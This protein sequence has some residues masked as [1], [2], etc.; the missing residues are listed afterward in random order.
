MKT[1]NLYSYYILKNKPPGITAELYAYTTS[2]KYAKEFESARNMKIFRKEKTTIDKES[3]EYL[4]REYNYQYLVEYSMPVYDTKRKIRYDL[5]YI[6]TKDECVTINTEAISLMYTDIYNNCWFSP[7]IFKKKIHD[8]LE[9]LNYNK[10]F[11]LIS[12]NS[13]HPTDEDD[14]DLKPDRLAIF[15]RYYG[16]T[17][18]G[19]DTL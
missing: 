16:K 5:H 9:V 3:L 17:L 10:I 12:V 1:Y 2:K 15:L 13:Q 19:Y 7:R 6:L 8:A 14:L 4:S 18:K 11:Y